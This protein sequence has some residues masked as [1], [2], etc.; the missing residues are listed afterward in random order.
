MAELRE[1]K[2]VKMS[3]SVTQL[4]EGDKDVVRDNVR[5]L[6]ETIVRGMVDLPE[7]IV[8]SYSMGE[9]TTIFKVDCDQ[10]CLGQII[11]AKGKNISGLRAIVAA[12][13]ARQGIRAI[14]EI[15][16]FAQDDHED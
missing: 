16:F 12:T 14:V 13:M 4:K 15:P 9:K 3:K 11:G 6:V 2:V 5:M 7:S 8:V 1:V 10:K